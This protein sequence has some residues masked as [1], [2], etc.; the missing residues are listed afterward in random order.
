MTTTLDRE[1]AAREARL[2]LDP[3]FA[4]RT[5]AVVGASRNRTS[6]GFSLVHNLVV[7]E[8]AGAIY[9]VNPHA[10]SIHSLKAYPSVGAIP[11]P[12]D[13]AVVAVPRGAVKGVV[14]ECLA[15]GVRG[16]VVI[17]A[18]FAETGEEGAAR[19]AEL[20]EL[21][22]GRGV[23]MIGPNCMGVI[24]TDP[25]V[26]LNA[27]FAPTPANPG[28]I[29][30]VSQSGALGVASLNVAQDRGVGLTQFVSMGNKAD[31][32][33]NDLLEYWEEDAATRVIA[34]YLESFGNPRRFTEI[35]K[36]V[37]R[38][39]PILVVKSGRTTEGARAAS[40]HTGAIAGADVTVSAFLEQCGVVRANTI[41]ELFDLAVALDRC[42]LALGNRVAI[43]TN[44]G[45]PAIM[46]TDACVNLGL[47][48]AELSEATRTKLRSFLAAE[49]SVANPVDMIASATAGDYA[50]SLATVL[51][52]PNVD[53]AMVINV[54]PLLANPIDVMEEIGQVARGGEV[55]VLAVMMATEE[56]YEGIK[57]RGDL[58]PVY[59]FPEPA[60]R[61]LA[62]LV[63]YGAW[64]RRPAAEEP[65]E[66]AADDAAVAALLEATG[67]GYL[68]P[69][70]AFRVLE[71]Y[72]IPVAGWRYAE[73]RD[74]ALAAALGR[75]GN[76]S[77]G[78]GAAR[79]EAPGAAR[80][81]PLAF[82]LV[83]KAHAPD[84]VHKSD[85]GGVEVGIEDE[86]ALGRALAAIEERLSAAGH[87]PE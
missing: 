1:T 51:E 57:G 54:T 80:R 49:A 12:V 58:P 43:V 16:L 86:A 3:I 73:D 61:V 64:R 45:G 66:I 5:V 83:A 56:F 4:P 37:G 50:R 81:E 17:T 39:K 22:R 25:E 76:A 35:A 77:A 71:L 28:S 41:E 48:I 53:L 21:V 30:F 62:Q 59:R 6:I 11:D 9:P 38:K 72:G 8:F 27:T 29:G 13:L 65:P 42:P 74:G 15:A 26:R 87:P 68:P 70:A 60:A 79:A 33:G 55:P 32:S 18:G 44:A 2:G 31:V 52:D 40:S 10:A 34:M 7:Q 63:R 24:N 85:V 46:A 82:P 23:R 19:E 20:R 36:R 47:E 67:E 78:G 84:V 75:D 14:E 69:D